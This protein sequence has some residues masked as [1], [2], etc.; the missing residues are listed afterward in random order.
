VVETLFSANYPQA[1]S[2]L[3]SSAAGYVNLSDK[4]TY[5]LQ[6]LFILRLRERLIDR[7]RQP[8]PVFAANPVGG[9]VV[10]TL[11]SANYPQATSVLASSAA[12]YVN[13]SDK[14]TFPLYSAAAGATHRPSAPAAARLC[15][16][17]RRRPLS[18]RPR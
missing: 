3:A 17:S 16:E 6:H 2:V 9:R 5:Q 4:L 13:L 15:C 1:T 7:Q 14:L 10:E 18:S 8:L 12:G 11:F